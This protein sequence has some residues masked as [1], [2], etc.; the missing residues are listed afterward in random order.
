MLQEVMEYIN[1]YFVPI[2]AKKVEYTIS[3]GMISP[4]FGAE[5]GDRFLICGSRR[6]DG[7]YTFHHSVIKNDD[8]ADVAGLR[9][10][11]FAGTIRVCSVPPAL[12]TLSEEI[13][14]WVETNSEL[15]NSP[16]QSESFNGY[17]YTLKSGTR[18]GGAAQEEPLTWRKMFGSRLARWRSMLV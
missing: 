12:L 3:N 9:D 5:D 13:S 16:L 18:S 4:S 7:V 8:D 6:N 2:S 17:S 1:N 15:L 14:Q 10:E 11:T